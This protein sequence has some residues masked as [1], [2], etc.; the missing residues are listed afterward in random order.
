MMSIT[1]KKKILR[2]V[3]G[4]L[5]LFPFLAL[6]FL[7][8]VIPVVWGI[9]ISFASYDLMTPLQWVGFQNYITLFTADDL[10]LVALKNTLV[11][12]V[13]SGPIGFISSFFFAWV[14]H[15]LKFRNV[16]ALAFYVPSIMSSLA[17]S[18][19]WLSLFS[20]NRTGIVNNLLLKLGIIEDAISWTLDPKYI[21]PLIILISVWMSM[22]T[23]FLTSL[24]GLSNINQDIYEAGKIDGIRNRFQELFLLT[25]PQMKPQLF[26]NG[27]MSI[28]NSLNVYD[29][30]TQ[31]AGAESPDNCALTLTAHMYDYGF[32]RFE[33]G[34]ASAISVVLMLISVILGQIVRSLFSEKEVRYEEEI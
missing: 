6:F 24:A 12:A 23:G 29:L 22:G 31:I 7:F 30:V 9:V 27:I 33:L 5:F 2:N 16:F 4:Y 26:F 25:I 28:V 8:I 19:V 15:Q 21:M 3:T 34:Y 18:V 14:I 13:I 20:S 17:V 32:A 1:R 10:F 11:F